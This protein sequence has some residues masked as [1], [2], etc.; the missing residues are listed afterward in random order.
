MAYM[1]EQAHVE[2][3]RHYGI[4]SHVEYFSHFPHI[5]TIADEPC[6]TELC[7]LA[8][9]INEIISYPLSLFY[10]MIGFGLIILIILK[11]EK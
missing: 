3:Y 11:E 2:I 4:D 9:N 7:L 5:V 8:N 1:H 6:P 10:F